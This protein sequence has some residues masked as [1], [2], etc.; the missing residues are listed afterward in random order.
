MIIPDNIQVALDAIEEE[1][2]FALEAEY[3]LVEWLE[4]IESGC[5][6]SLII[7]CGSLSRSRAWSRTWSRTWSKSYSLSLS[8][9][10]NSRSESGSGSK[11]ESLSKTRRKSKSCSVTQSNTHFL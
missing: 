10:I 6:S 1:N 9:L 7:L 5:S 8:S 4:E 3:Q 2:S 11:Y